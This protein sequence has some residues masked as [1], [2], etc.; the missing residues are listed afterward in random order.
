[1]YT[2][3]DSG[4]A[5]GVPKDPTP[6]EYL[7][8]STARRVLQVA[9]NIVFGLPFL[10]CLLIAVRG[11]D[12]WSSHRVFGDGI[13]RNA[14]LLWMVAAAMG[15][16]WLGVTLMLTAARAGRIAGALLVVVGGALLVGFHP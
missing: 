7:Q 13:G 9:V 6:T 15:A 4:F 16:L 12:L 10:W 8:V 2:L 11:R 14:D 1:M 5:G 3:T